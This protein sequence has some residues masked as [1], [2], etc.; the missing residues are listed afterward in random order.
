MELLLQRFSTGDES[1]LGILHEIDD[2]DEVRTFQCFTMEDQPNE[3]KVPGETRIPAGR[4][5][6]LLRPKGGNMNLRYAK[7]FDGHAGM[8]W[9]QDVPDFTW[10]YIHVGNT[11]DDSEGCILVGDGCQSNVLEDGM[12]MSSVAAYTRLYD[13]IVTALHDAEE[14]WISIEDFD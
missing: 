6:I 12:V 4:Y 11:D 14:V 10:V 3:P 13:L 7:R 9:L 1:T 2:Y 8:L 5:R